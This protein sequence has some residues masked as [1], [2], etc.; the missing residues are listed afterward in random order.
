M[1]LFDS[2]SIKLKELN[3]VCAGKHGLAD[4]SVEANRKV[5]KTKDQEL[6][7]GYIYHAGRFGHTL[8]EL[9]IMLLRPPNALSG[10]L[11]ELVRAGK[12]VVSEERRTTRTGSRAR[13]YK[14]PTVLQEVP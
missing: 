7:Y 11:T 8:D 14:I 4:T 6:I 13:V 3:D 10:R 12:I 5:Q 1:D 2:G 9:S